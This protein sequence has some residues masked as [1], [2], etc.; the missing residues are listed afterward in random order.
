MASAFHNALE[1]AAVSVAGA[2]V[3]V[4]SCAVATS[5]RAFA[6]VASGV[7][8]VVVLLLLLIGGG[9]ADALVVPELS[10]S[11]VVLIVPMSF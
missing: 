1:I 8:A 2:S 6:A 11:D 7:A 5:A 10:L 3:I 9:V 4:V